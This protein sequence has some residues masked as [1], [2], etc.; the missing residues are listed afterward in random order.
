MMEV[1]D[2]V[3]VRR[4]EQHVPEEIVLVGTTLSRAVQPGWDAANDVCILYITAARL[5][6]YDPIIGRCVV[7]SGDLQGRGLAMTSSVTASRFLI[8][9]DFSRNL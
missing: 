9:T 5:V 4:T 1:W 2:R 3:E 7:D 6:A 8:E